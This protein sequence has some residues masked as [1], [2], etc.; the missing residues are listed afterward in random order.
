M[1]AR[2]RIEGTLRQPEL[3]AAFDREAEHAQKPGHSLIDF[4]KS[5]PSRRWSPEDGEWI[6]TGTGINPQKRF[7][8]AGFTIDLGDDEFADIIDLDDLVE[9]VSKLA[10]N[11]REVFIRPRLL[12]FEP[13]LALLG[14][15]ASWDRERDSVSRSP[16]PTSFA[17]VNPSKASTSTTRPSRPP[18]TPKAA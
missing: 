9:P 14:L 18:A 11:K 1:K 3:H 15:S 13:T 4:I 16:W 12:G 17:Q 5:M 7:T 10:K 8:R 6:I 2:L